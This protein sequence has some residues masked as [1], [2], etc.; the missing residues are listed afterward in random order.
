MEPDGEKILD[1]SHA[2]MLEKLPKSALII[3][4]A[5]IGVEFATIWSAYG[6]EVHLV[7][8]LPH[9]LPAED[10]EAAAELTKALGKRGVKVYAGT[11]VLAVEK[12]EGGTRVTLA[13]ENG[14]QSV[15]TE[16]H[17]LPWVLDPTPGT[18]GSRHWACSW[19]NAVSWLWMG[20]CAPTFPAFAPSGT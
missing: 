10:N 20:K 3:A 5:R 6:V 4:A 17:W 11:K 14:E 8:M 7:E 2:I 12:I 15:E 13:N 9:I 1:Y 18:W 19:T 16:R